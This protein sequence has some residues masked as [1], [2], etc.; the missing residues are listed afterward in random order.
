MS[1]VNLSKVEVACINIAAESGSQHLRN[2]IQMMYEIDMPIPSL[3]QDAWDIIKMIEG[4]SI[5]ETDSTKLDEKK[6]LTNQWIEW[7]NLQKGK[8]A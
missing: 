5:E 7:K 2:F 4:E 8:G 1:S 6:T 3:S